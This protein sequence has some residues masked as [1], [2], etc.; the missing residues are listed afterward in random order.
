MTFNDFGFCDEL[1]KAIQEAGFREPSPIQKQSI[2]RILQG[3]DLIGQAQT[4]TG[5]T[6]A[7]G[8]PI[9]EML[10]RSQESPENQGGQQGEQRGRY[11]KVAA[12]V[13][14]PTRE[15]AIQVASELSR[16]AQYLHLKTATVYGGQPYEK[17]LKAFRNAHIIVATP[18][19][20]LD[21]L[22]NNKVQVEPQFVV[23]DE[24]D[25]MLNMGFLDDIR[26]IFS[27]FGL[28]RQNLL[29]SATLPQAIKALIREILSEPEF[30][31][32][33]GTTASDQVQQSFY[34]VDE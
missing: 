18:G 17:Q 2:P 29:F 13:I 10:Y 6:A 12:F 34:V 33:S 8:L 23:L 25:E 24:A 11:S 26:E 4:G 30:V 16:F 9:I 31:T 21:I 14:V 1:S 32:L 3:K 28:E 15:L 19:R 27:H 5:K 20:L 7:F 22:K